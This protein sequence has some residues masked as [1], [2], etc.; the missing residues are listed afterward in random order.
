MDI[1][2]E[3]FLGPAIGTLLALQKNRDPFQNSTALKHYKC[4]ILQTNVL[5]ITLFPPI[6]WLNKM[7]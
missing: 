1:F 6:V 5:Y 2:L 3:L 4:H 7:Y